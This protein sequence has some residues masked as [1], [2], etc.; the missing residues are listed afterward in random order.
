MTPTSVHVTTTSTVT[1]DPYITTETATET[2]STD[3]YVT[4]TVVEVSF[5]QSNKKSID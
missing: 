4:S 1:G 3:L 2:T 5:S